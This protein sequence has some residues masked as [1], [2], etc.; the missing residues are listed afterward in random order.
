MAHSVA[1]AAVSEMKPGRYPDMSGYDLYLE[2]V[3]QFLAEWSIKPGDIQGLLA[4]PSGM[5]EGG[6]NDIFV[7]E[8]LY[9]ELGIHPLF[10]DTMNAGG[11]TYGLMVQRAALAIK[12]GIADSVLCIG[13]GKFPKVG[14]GGAE[15]MARMISHEIYEFPYGTFIPAIYAQVASR[16]MFE[17]GTT[18]EQFAEVA[19][20]SREWALKNPAAAM[21]GTESLSVAKVRESRPI[22]T[23]FHLYD[24]S[25]PLEGGAAILVTS[26]ATA[27]RFTSQPAYLLGMGEYHSHRNIHQAPSLTDVGCNKAG[28]QAYRS[29]GL[30]P[31]DMDFAQIYD[32]FSVNPLVF[33]E[34]LELCPK[35][36]GGEFFQSGASRP[37]GDFPVNTYGGL[38]S[39][40]HTGDASGMSMIVEGARQIMGIAGERQLD[41]ADIGLVHSYGGMMSEHSTLIFGR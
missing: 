36:R 29:A 3:R 12:Q 16:H 39:F 30:G 11:S 7:H 38:L 27:R 37:G 40:G 35:G 13:A 22:A 32:A 20:S 8:Q 5:A 2:V 14:A 19:V 33:M 25:I 6:S 4:C 21:Y 28:Q 34:E 24:C 10:A 26:P 41:K 1:I 15:S 18:P 17:Y 9:E 31:G 23:P